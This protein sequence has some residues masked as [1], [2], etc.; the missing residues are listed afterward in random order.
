MAI[1]SVG[2]GLPTWP[3]D[4]LS[5]WLVPVVTPPLTPRQLG[6]VPATLRGA[7]RRRSG[8]RKMDGGKEK[9]R[10]TFFFFF[11]FFTLAYGKGQR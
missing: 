11:F 8:D 1:V 7:E 5:W 9:L 6:K 2:E 4:E 10:H 3:C